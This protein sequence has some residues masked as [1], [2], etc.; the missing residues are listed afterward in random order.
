M[1]EADVR[2][3]ETNKDLMTTQMAQAKRL[4]KWKNYNEIFDNLTIQKTVPTSFPIVS[5]MITYDSTRTILVTKEDDTAYHIRQFSLTTQELVCTERYGGSANSYIKMKDV[6]QNA[7]GD[8]YAIAYIDDGNFKL[9]VFDKEPRTEEQ[10]LAKELDINKELGLNDYTMPI[11]GFGDPYITCTFVTDKILFVNLFHNGDSKHYHFFFNSETRE[12]FGKFDHFLEGMSPLN[13]PY[14]CFWNETQQEIYTFYRQG[15]A[16]RIKI[17]KIE[18]TETYETVET[19]AEKIT[20]VDLGTMFLI[21]ET[22][23]VCRSSGN[24][25]FFKR[26]YDEKTEKWY[27]TQYHKLQHKGL[28]YFIKGNIRINITTDEKIFFYLVNNAEYTPVLENV[29]YNHM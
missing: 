29:M 16:Y 24:I 21:K 13:F 25:L 23:L 17:K 5:C 9:R 6:E 10:A 15:Q 20:D 7:V 2:I 12:I 1:E 26:I 28:L 19:Q 3:G 8:R 22:C 14:K 4:S 11:D 18:G 27:W